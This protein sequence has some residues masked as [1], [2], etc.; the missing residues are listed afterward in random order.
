MIE[1]YYFEFSKIYCRLM[2]LE[3]QLKRMLISSLLP[4]YKENII[5]TFHKFLYNKDRLN[6]YNSQKGNSILAILKNP[7]ITNSQKFK[8]VINK[9]YLSDLLFMVLHCEQFR[10]EEI[11]NNFYFKIPEKFRI[12]ISSKQLLLDLRNTIAHYNFKDYE[13][14]K[15]NYL[16]TLLLFEV[17]MGKNMKGILEF[18]KFVE[19][20]SIKT[21]LLAIKDLRPDLL[22]IDFDKDDEMEYFYNKHRVLMDL[23]D[24]I[25]L[26]NGYETKEL[27]SP[28]TILRQMYSLRQGHK[29]ISASQ[30]DIYSLPLFK[31][32]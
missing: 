1:K 32:L 24:E 3:I 6:R 2:R 20:P 31:N 4:Y 7:Q 29:S 16:D 11:T 13:Q 10:K 27:P 22:D 14:N 9:L 19:K 25:A 15:Y 30:D 8:N 28:W 18:P 23:C 17:H 12:L 5:N 21:I 26:Y